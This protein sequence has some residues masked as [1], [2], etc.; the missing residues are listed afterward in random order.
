M[1]CKTV[2]DVLQGDEGRV[3]QN[4]LRDDARG[5]QVAQHKRG[6]HVAAQGQR[7]EL[8]GRA[9]VLPVVLLA[10]VHTVQ[11]Q[12]GARHYVCAQGAVHEPRLGYRVLVD[13]VRELHGRV[14]RGDGKRG[15]DEDGRGVHHEERRER[16][17]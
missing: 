13:G 10:L 11:P 3:A 16:V 8:R 15:R 14:A 7:R 6:Q 17:G 2:R 9:Q 1:A 5:S 12:R 4:I